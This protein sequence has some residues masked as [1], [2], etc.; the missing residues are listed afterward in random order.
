MEKAVLFDVDDTLY[1]QTRPFVKAYKE[2][3]ADRFEIRAERIFPVTRKY[4]D[5]V[6]SRAMAGKIT[7][8]ELY[9]YRVQKAFEEYGVQISREE[10]L[11]FQQVYARCQNEI[12]MSERMERIL[13]FCSQRVKTGIITN[14]P[15]AHQ[16]N[17]VRNL[18][19]D[20]W[21]PRE[22]IFVSAD[23]GAE[24]PRKEIFEYAGRVMGLE[25]AEVYF[26]GDSYDS[27]MA[28]AMNVGW[29]GIWINRRARQIP[30]GGREPDFEVET[31]EELEKVLHQLIAE[32]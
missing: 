6:Y 32:D 19:A 29:H 17:K 4:S 8:E 25:G 10:S 2:Y 1:D 9:V 18:Q 24:K 21:I 7:M 16:W 14:G 22:N 5:Q 23:V 30:E 20:R 12:E 31:E 11:A 28:G 13:S 15:S 27:D 3:F 26:V